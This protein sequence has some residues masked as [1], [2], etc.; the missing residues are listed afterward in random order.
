LK[1][2]VLQALYRILINMAVVGL[3]V[4]VAQNSYRSFYMI[5]RSLIELSKVVMGKGELTYFF[6]L[7]LICVYVVTTL[8]ILASRRLVS[9]DGKALVLDTYALFVATTLAVSLYFVATEKNFSPNFF[10]QFLGLAFLFRLGAFGAASAL[11]GAVQ[12]SFSMLVKQLASPFGLVTVFVVLLPGL[13][14]GGYKKD[15]RIANLIHSTRRAISQTEKIPYDVKPLQQNLFFEQPIEVEFDSQGNMYVLERVGRL[16]MLKSAGSDQESQ[17]AKLG[18]S[19]GPLELQKFLLADF[20]KQVGKVAVENGALGFALHPDFGNPGSPDSNRFF[21]AYTHWDNSILKNRLSE[22]LVNENLL[23]QALTPDQETA[24]ESENQFELAASA[25]RESILIEQT[26][27]SDGYHNAGAV[28]FGPDGF[29]YI[30]VGEATEK[31]NHQQIDYALYSGILRIDIDNQAESLP[32]SKQPPGGITQGYKIPQDNPFVVHPGA[33]Q[34]FYAL[35]FRNPFRISFDKATGKLWAGDV[36]NITYEEI[37]IVEPGGNYQFPYAE[38]PKVGK[39][40][41]PLIGSEKR[42]YFYYV[43]TALNRA[44]IGGEVYRE[45]SSMTFVGATSMATITQ[46]ES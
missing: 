20:S 42:S 28:E 30:A 24:S 34:E 7:V 2:R 37:N 21:V 38:G 14:L 41:V 25:V 40:P 12:R 35:G 10:V 6:T 5:P 13:L 31:K 11:T 17:P 26:R 22:F 36:G 33:L 43:H 8:V 9:F 32:I 45:S 4:T 39:K 27:A 15:R 44:I 16:F 19:D 3:A 23:D 1:S 46:A 18:Q 29:L